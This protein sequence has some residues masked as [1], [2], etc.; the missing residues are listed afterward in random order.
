M[1]TTEAIDIESFL[2]CWYHI[3]SKNTN[4]LT[5][6][7]SL[8]NLRQDFSGYFLI[9]SLSHIFDLAN[10]FFANKPEEAKFN[11]ILPHHCLKEKFPVEIKEI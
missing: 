2:A 6:S 4:L 9:L 7:L 1:D 11:I 10:L 8:L 3:I 5:L